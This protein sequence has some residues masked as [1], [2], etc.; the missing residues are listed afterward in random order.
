MQEL[1]SDVG[2][3]GSG[4]LKTVR[5]QKRESSSTSSGARKP[6]VG[7]EGE[8]P[9]RLRPRGNVCLDGERFIAIG[10]WARAGG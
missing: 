9:A 2:S 4:D 5:E 8:L 10:P 7:E 6:S 3:E 1:S